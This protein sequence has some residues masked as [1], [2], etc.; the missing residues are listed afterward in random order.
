VP[1]PSELRKLEAALPPAPDGT[2]Y[3]YGNPFRCPHCAAPFIDFQADP[4]MRPAE[5]Y[6]N[7]L[8]GSE[9]LNY[10]PAP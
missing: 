5:Y 8:V 3:S 6:G 2:S 10:E 9:L 1:D 4:A 7:V